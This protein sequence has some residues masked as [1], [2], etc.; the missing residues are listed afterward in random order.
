MPAHD[1]PEPVRGAA[2]LEEPVPRPH[3]GA[4]AGLGEH[5]D[6]SV[7]HAAQEG[8]TGK[9]RGTGHGDRF[10]MGCA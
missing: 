4:T 3:R 7:R 9:L 2:L 1:E 5:G 6:V 8:M 10:A